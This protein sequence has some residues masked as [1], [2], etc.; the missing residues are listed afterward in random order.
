MLLLL[1]F[2]ELRSRGDEL[3]ILEQ[4]HRDLDSSTINDERETRGELRRGALLAASFGKTTNTVNNDLISVRISFKADIVFVS[5]TG[6]QDL[7]VE[8]HLTNLAECKDN[9]CLN[10]EAEKESD[11]FISRVNESSLPKAP[12]D[13]GICKVCGVDKDDDNVSMFFCVIVVI[14][15]FI[16][17]AWTHHLSK[18]LMEI[19]IAL[20]II[21]DHIDQCALLSADL[22][23]KLRSLNSELKALKLREEFFTADLAKVKN[24]IGHGGDFGS[25][26]FSSGVVS[27]VK[28]NGQVSES[29]A[30]SLSSNFSRQC[31]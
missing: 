25:N 22:Q 19:D 26:A 8:E 4:R 6:L 11:D 7:R 14:P 27:D 20:P 23:Q 29:G 1:L 15:S 28:L 9:N 30:Q 13:E 5:G 16:H 24:N 12:W 3:R 10:S 31:T 18:F 21:R 2:F 17:I